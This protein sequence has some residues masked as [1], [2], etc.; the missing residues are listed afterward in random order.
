MD[1]QRKKQLREEYKYRK[2][3]MGIISFRCAAAEEAFL[4]ASQ[5]TQADINTNRFKLSAN[6]HPN[7]KMQELWNRYGETGF[8]ASV[9]RVLAYEN[10]DDNH[11]E[12]LETLLTQCLASDEGSCKML[13]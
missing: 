10:P 1:T 11:T 5:N 4:C 12:S 2:P 9:V 8:E 7:K 6:C 3:E 13:K